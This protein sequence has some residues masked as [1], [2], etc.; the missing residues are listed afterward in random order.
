MSLKETIK[1]DLLKAQKEADRERV[2]ILK[3][4]WSEIGYL[5]VERQD[6]D[7]G[8]IA[9]LKK[10][11]RKRK[12]SIEIYEK[13]GDE[14]RLAGEKYELEVIKSYLPEEMGEAEIR[15]E[16]ERIAKETGITGGRLIGE[17]MKVLGGKAD[18]KLV[19]RIVGE[20]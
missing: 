6:N 7:E 11:A 2:A 16:V 14:E 9:M 12:D 10:E 20:M 5:M 19:A 8:I 18:G 13:A 17:V 4:L 3:L 15:K 1:K